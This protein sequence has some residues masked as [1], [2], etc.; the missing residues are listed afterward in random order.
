MSV[1][2]FKRETGTAAIEVKRNPNTGKLFFTYGKETGA[3][4]DSF[5]TE[6]TENTVIS[7]VCS[8]ETGDTFFLLHN[9]GKGACATL[10]RF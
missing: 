9:L 1:N 4:S 5:N 6:N 2:D 3:V 8:E 7:E 10:A